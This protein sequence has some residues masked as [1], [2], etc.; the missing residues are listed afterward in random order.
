MFNLFKKK[1]VK[2]TGFIEQAPR[3]TDYLAGTL[4]YEVRLLNGDWKDYLPEYEKQF[5]DFSFDT[6]SCT[7]FSFLN[8]LE[9]QLNY[10]L[11]NLLLS[12][13]QVSFLTANDYIQNGKINF[14]DR[15]L[16][17]MSD[18]TF[19]GNTFVNVAD[20]ARTLGLVPES[21]LPFGGNSFNEY[22]NKN[23]I[24]QEIKNLG[25]EF[26]KH[27]SIFYEFVGFND[28]DKELKHVPLQIAVPYPEPKHAEMMT[29]RFMVLDQ[30]PP[31]YRVNL[32]S[33]AYGFKILIVGIE[34][35][36]F[37]ILKRGSKGEEVKKLQTKLN[38]LITN[39]SC[40]GDFGAKTEQALKLVQGALNIRVDGIYGS[41]TK[42]AL[43]AKNWLLVTNFS[44]P[45]DDIEGVS[46]ILLR[47][48]QRVRNIVK[49][50]MKI[51]SGKRT[52]DHNKE[53]GGSEHSSHITGL[54]FDIVATPEKQEILERE[55]A[56][57]GVGRFG[58]Y[59]NHI[60]VDIDLSKPNAKWRG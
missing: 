34:D 45:A 46:L 57:L 42:N 30:Y 47:I 6:M 54:A 23:L 59:K 15:A 55:F 49:F 53:V 22:H 21:M 14:S 52:P 16:A 44:E 33:I 31:F 25:K 18:T 58:K 4:P 20:T 39:V 13:E 43:E 11:D 17:I 37:K 3:P 2:Q 12:H 36:T 29:S 27:F 8:V 41:N 7:T 32:K 9:T 40:D 51:S 48:T 60:H 56:K 10:L 24:S 1:I 28:Y 35:K 50:P 5:K 26:L 19:R 38:E